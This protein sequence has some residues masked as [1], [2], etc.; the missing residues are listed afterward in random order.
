[1]GSSPSLPDIYGSNDVT[2][3]S[4]TVSNIPTDGRAIYVTLWSDVNG[5]WVSTN[6]TY[7]ASSH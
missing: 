5:N 4:L 7:K 2:V 3:H 1:V 6:Y